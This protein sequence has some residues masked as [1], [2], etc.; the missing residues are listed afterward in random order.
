MSKIA[1]LVLVLGC[2]PRVNPQPV[3]LTAPV[4]D[5][6]REKPQG[7]PECPNGHRE[8]IKFERATSC[9]ND[10]SVEFCLSDSSAAKA[11]IAAISPTITCSPG[12]GQAQCRAPGLLLC[13]YPTRH[14][15]QCTTMQ[16]PMTDALWSDMCKLAALSDVNEIVPTWYE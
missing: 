8:K 10:G 1:C 9:S 12:G 2:S 11:R 6:V 14:V 16:S 3:G 4:A 13:S 5:G 7:A 15:G